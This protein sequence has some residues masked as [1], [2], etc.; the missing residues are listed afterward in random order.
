MHRIWLYWARLRWSK[1]RPY[2]IQRS[3]LVLSLSVVGTTVVLVVL[4][5]VSVDSLVRLIRRA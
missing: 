5:L 3:L 2:V 1:R 4:G